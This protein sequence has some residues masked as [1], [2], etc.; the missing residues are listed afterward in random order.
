MSLRQAKWAHRT[1]KRLEA[2]QRKLDYSKLTLEQRIAR[3]DSTRQ[4][5]IKERARILLAITKRGTK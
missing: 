1:K 5:A 4:R 3:L 2:T